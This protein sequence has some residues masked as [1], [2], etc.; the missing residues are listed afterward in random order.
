MQDCVTA[1]WHKHTCQHVDRGSLTGPIMTQKRDNL[2]LFDAQSQ[3]INS[4]ELTKLHGHASELDWIPLIIGFSGVAQ[5]MVI[6]LLCISL[7]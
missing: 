3:V 7:E 6:G 2:V 1:T 4:F 5:T